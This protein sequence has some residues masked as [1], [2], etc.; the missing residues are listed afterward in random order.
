VV[1]DA[2]LTS[3]DPPRQ[4]TGAWFA[5]DPVKQAPAGHR[6]PGD[7]SPASLQSGPRTFLRICMLLDNPG[8]TRME[9][10]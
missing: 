9:G 1:P 2:A 6:A 7:L 8:L 10:G 4:A 3:V 5:V